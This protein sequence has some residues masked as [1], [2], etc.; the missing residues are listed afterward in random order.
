MV[1][2]YGPPFTIRQQ[3]VLA[4]LPKCT[5]LLSSLFS[6]YVIYTIVHD[7]KRRS[8][9][10]HRLLL[11][12]SLCELSTAL[13]TGLSTW[14][15]PT[16]S[17]SPYGAVG[18][19]A[20]CTV[21]GFWLQFGIAGPCYNASLSFYYLF[22]IRY[23][24][25][26]T[27]LEFWERYCFHIIPLLW[28]IISSLIGL[29]LRVYG[30]VSLWCWVPTSYWIFR[31]LAFEGPL[32]CVIAIVTMN[33][34]MVYTHVRKVDKAAQKH[35][36]F[37][38]SLRQ[39]YYQIC[40]DGNNNNNLMNDP[41]NHDEAPNRLNFGENPNY[42]INDH[43]NHMDGHHQVEPAP[44]PRTLKHYSFPSWHSSSRSLH[45]HH[46]RRSVPYHSNDPTPPLAMP[47][48]R[49]FFTTRRNQANRGD[50]NPRMMHDDH[51]T[52]HHDHSYSATDEGTHHDHHHGTIIEQANHYHHHISNMIA[53]ERHPHDMMVPSNPLQNLNKPRPGTMV[54][55]TTNTTTTL[56]S[57]STTN[58]PSTLTTTTGTPGYRRGSINERLRQSL[59]AVSYLTTT[60]TTTTAEHHPHDHHHHVATILQQHKRICKTMYKRTERTKEVS[61]Q[62]LL[63]AG[64][65]YFTWLAI[66]VT[67]IIQ[68][69]N[70]RTYYPLL[71]LSVLS[72]PFQG[73]A[74]FLVYIAP[75]I[76]RLR[77]KREKEQQ[78]RRRESQIHGISGGGSSHHHTAHHHHHHDNN[79][80]D[81]T[82]HHPS[83]G[84]WLDVIWKVLFSIH[85]T[86][87][88]PTTTTTITASTTATAND[89]RN[90][91]DTEEEDDDEDEAEVEEELEK[92]QTSMIVFDHTHDPPL[93][94]QMN[95]HH[96]IEQ[97]DHHPPQY[98]AMH[99]SSTTTLSDPCLSAAEVEDSV[100]TT[101]NIDDVTKIIHHNPTKRNACTPSSSVK[102]S[103]VYLRSSIQQPPLPTITED[104]SAIAN[105]I[106]AMEDFSDYGSEDDDDDDDSDS[107]DD[108][109]EDKP[110][111]AEKWDELEEYLELLS[112]E[113]ERRSQM[114]T[115][116]AM[117]PHIDHR[118]SSAGDSRR[119]SESIHFDHLMRRSTMFGRSRNGGGNSSRYPSFIRIGGDNNNSTNHHHNHNESQYLNDSFSSTTNEDEE[120]LRILC[121]R[122]T[123]T[124]PSKGRR[125][126]WT[127]RSTRTA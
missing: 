32:W 85:T 119:I 39:T 72:V 15:I 127:M 13:W 101:N 46:H 104:K 43:H 91:F 96:S 12:I 87:P 27:Q 52:S 95:N 98:A 36:L 66:T 108:D 69:M 112:V 114:I 77:K 45:D 79:S 78:K 125:P 41:N 56:S 60:T 59:F 107:E 48:W 64:G 54:E 123:A 68:E 110:L 74:N 33:I 73:F 16:S 94:E 117:L 50:H 17:S 109:E 23:G 51:H 93:F 75:R 124:N 37:Q 3:R 47:T 7:T 62:C 99:P 89:V 26:E 115:T 71:V 6:L 34:S 53:M 4:I 65:F 86:A 55:T 121:R 103:S 49:S 105:D 76:R 14:P 92:S 38:N 81:H 8:R 100:T 111:D 44:P 40:N 102:R 1:Y 80:N 122:S 28:G 88:P 84:G 29:Y 21:Q 20:T 9:I 24:Y 70:G 97:Q 120:F 83:I 58:T 118:I 116:T 126:K 35:R 18:N 90:K 2:P 106:M 11:G 67:R 30:S 19:I 5:G 82:N 63:Y 61:K 10:Y 31:Y 25:K 22:V 57:T 113:N 42:P